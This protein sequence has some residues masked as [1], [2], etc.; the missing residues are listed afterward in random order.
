MTRRLSIIILAAGL[1]GALGLLLVGRP[2]LSTSQVDVLAADVD[3]RVREAAAA[4]QARATTLAELPRLAWAVATDENTVLDLT[5]EELAFRP[6]PGEVIEIGQVFRKD[7]SIVSLRRVGS[8]AVLH[9]PL[10]AP[11]HHLIAAGGELHAAEVVDVI[12]KERAD[13]LVGA[14]AVSRRVELAP[15]AERLAQAGVAAR[16]ETAAGSVTLGSAPADAREQPYAFPPEVPVKLVLLLPEEQIPAPGFLLAAGLL[17]LV[18]GIGAKLAWRR[19]TGFAAEFEETQRVNRIHID[20]N[21][22]G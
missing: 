13:E 11:G 9:L 8:A 2:G 7:R 4:A 12:P 14:V 20:L 15:V 21:Q 16:I 3:A 1:G 19:P 17:L 5:A 10:A 6:Q 22:R 18:S